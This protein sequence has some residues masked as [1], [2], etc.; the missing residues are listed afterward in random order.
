[1]DDI[2]FHLLGFCDVVH[3]MRCRIVN[4]DWSEMC[5]KLIR[6]KYE[7][8]VSYFIEAC[9]YKCH[10]IPLK[11]LV[12]YQMKEVKMMH[13]RYKCA[14]CG[15]PIFKVGVCEY[16]HWNRV[17]LLKKIF[18]GPSFCLI[19]ATVVLSRFRRHPIIL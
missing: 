9:R 19:L 10:K 18:S 13:P 3:L 17:K 1:M 6:M 7:K 8:S 15:R 11:W 2:F 16:K 4:K 5:E 14:Y 12:R